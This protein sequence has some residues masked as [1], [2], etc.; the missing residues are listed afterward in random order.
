VKTIVEVEI[1]SQQERAVDPVSDT[2]TKLAR[3]WSEL[4]KI[5]EV[6]IHDDYFAL[7]GNSLLA[8]NLMARIEAQFGA[9]L[10]LTTILEAPTVAQFARVLETRGSH[11]PLVLIRKGGY[12][13]SLFLVHDADGETML[14]RSLAHHLDPEQA[15]YG[16]KAFSTPGHPIL[17]TRIEEMAAYH[18]GT[19]RAVQPR[20][21]Y[22]LGGLCAGGL[23][24]FEMARQL[25]QAGERVAM[26]ALMDVADVDAREKPMRWAK[27]R[28][29][30]VATTLEQGKG[31][32]APRRAL[33]FVGTWVRKARNFAKY[34]IESRV[35][36]IRDRTRMRLFRLYLG[37]GLPLPAFLRDIPVRSA[38]VYARGGYRPETP[39]HGELLL[40]R[41]T[42]G[43]GF[44]E[45]HAGRYIDP[46]MGWNSRS[47]RGVRAFDVPGGHS[48]MLQEPNVQVLAEHL[49]A[50]MHEVLKTPGR[51]Q[52]SGETDKAPEAEPSR[53][54]RPVQ[55]LVVSAE[56]QEALESRASRLEEH[57][58]EIGEQELPDVG[59]TLTVGR[60][61]FE[62]RRA[63]VAGSRGEAI[64]RLRKGTGRGVWSN[65]Q[66]ATNRPVAFVLAGVGEQAAGAGR[67][68]YEGEPAFRA[69]ADHCS[70]IL[71]PIM[72]LDIRESMFTPSPQAGNWLR[73]DAGV[74]KETRVSQPSAFVL[75]W[76]L[77]QMWLSWG[78]EPAAV[79]G[80]SVGEYAAAALA[81]VLRLEDALML[82]ARRAEWIEELAE[83]GAML[84][85]PL[86]E[87]EIRPRLGEA[88]WVA[89][90]NS[91][92]A[93]VVGGREEAI[94]RLE[95][96]LKA[97]DVVTR[98]VASDQGSH[99]P[100]LDPIRPHLKRLAEGMHRQPP[101]IPMLSNVTGTWISASESQ[102]PNHWC[103]HMCGTL[104]FEEGIGELL[105]DQEHVLLEVGP[106]AGLGAM[107][108][109]HPRFWRERTG[110]VLA[111]LPG[112]W[113]RVADRENVAGVLGRLW[114][115]GVDVDWERYYAG[116]D[117]RPVA[118]PDDRNVVNLVESRQ[119]GFLLGQGDIDTGFTGQ[120][121]GIA[122][123]IGTDAIR[124]TNEVR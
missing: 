1:A 94:R 38:Y 72:G 46:L 47:T 122:G 115:E 5:E 19:M 110:R 25:D 64:E 113:E 82:V 29:N 68:L 33:A 12:K 70:E 106:G 34:M 111:S 104:R 61:A 81:G 124:E 18:I 78:I 32:S 10:P 22:L 24:A 69:A 23:I 114:V 60:P 45:P 52:V 121:E 51:P 44:D 86:T 116:E 14:Y 87:A 11:S 100:L 31:R 55:L 6:G 41:A 16:L 21:P 74:L 3:L 59:Y 90:V 80:Y 95:E 112:A 84:A 2:E 42:S 53:P 118:L 107:V 17:H 88:L 120:S 93:T 63:V 36:K 9:K 92:Q 62:W 57:L 48:S 27:E 83:P 98:R 75:D 58:E 79:L 37:L 4:L 77:A 67:G 73:G 7:G 99:T 20:G 35:Q 40:I 119:G 65:S 123:P 102:D 50:Y 103:E 39:F 105:R 13:T 108:R 96:D 101:R 66:P 28:L 56:S 30:R 15:V 85:V 43:S 89:A 49:R 8:V 117:R 26:V 54:S 109:Q 97:A 91:P 71:R 76:A